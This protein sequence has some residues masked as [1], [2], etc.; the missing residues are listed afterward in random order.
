[1]VFYCLTRAHPHLER[2]YGV[3][4]HYVRHLGTCPWVFRGQSQ[5]VRSC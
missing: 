5:G 4:R 2:H 1:M 3:K